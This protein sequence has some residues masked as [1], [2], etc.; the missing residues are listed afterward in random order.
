V[1]KFR[2]KH[3]FVERPARSAAIP[4]PDENVR[5]IIFGDWG[6]GIPRALSVAKWIRNELD[7]P[8][9][10]NWQKHV[11][12]LGDVY[13]SGTQTEQQNYF[14]DNWCKILK[15]QCDANR[16]ITTPRP[17]TFSLPG[18]HDM[19]CGGQPYYAMI[20]QLGQQASFFSPVH[21]SCA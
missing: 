3:K 20:Q 5:M 14:F 9:I 13:Y 8:T 1:R 18:N 7:D 19:Y 16:N 15:L 6:S 17:A 4:F 21:K 11:I 12:H 10:K 2:G